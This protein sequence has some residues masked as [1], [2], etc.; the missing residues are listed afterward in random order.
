[1]HVNSIDKSYEKKVGNL[2]FY[3]LFSIKLFYYAIAFVLFDLNKLYHFTEYFHLPTSHS[4]LIKN[5]ITF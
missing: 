5:L 4:I 2:E 1:M 3:D